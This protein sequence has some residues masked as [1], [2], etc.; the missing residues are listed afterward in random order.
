MNICASAVPQLHKN[1]PLPSLPS[2]S[3]ALPSHL[4]APPAPPGRWGAC[5][6]ALSSS[7][8]T[9]PCHQGQTRGG[10]L[11]SGNTSA[12]VRVGGR[13][14]EGREGMGKGRK[15]GVKGKGGKG[16]RNDMQGSLVRRKAVDTLADSCT[17][18]NSMDSNH[19]N[20]K[21]VVCTT[22]GL[23]VRHFT[24]IECLVGV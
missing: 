7:S 22:R 24:H 23:P 2:P 14:G 21:H 1:G 16:G 15:G 12:P 11:W 10:T 5:E 6:R 19:R 3:P 13:R 18:Y 4:F 9:A 8:S 17:L 20:Y